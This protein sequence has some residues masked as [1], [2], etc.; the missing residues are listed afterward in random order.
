MR[1]SRHTLG[2]L[3]RRYLRRDEGTVAVEGIIV[4]PMLIFAL[5]FCYT[6]FAA[7]QAK[8]AANRAN[9]MISDYVS[10][11]TDT[12]DP[13]FMAGLGDVYRFLNNDGD[14]SLRI[15]S[16]KFVVDPV[17]SEESHELVWSYAEGKYE[18][19]TNETIAA[20][21]ARIPLLANGEEVVVVETERGW[22]P[23]FRVGLSELAF[24][25]IVT[26]KPRFTSQVIYDDG[27]SV[28]SDATHIDS[29]DSDTSVDGTQTGTNTSG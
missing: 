25:D 8:S 26:T 27:T 16:V 19:L 29:N 12:I 17:T 10:R 2:Q 13:T 6:Y 11:Q 3:A 7:F 1:Q 23:F 22:M 28:P 5:M 18:A 14:I 4:A 20:I 9:Y 15:S 21:E 24:A